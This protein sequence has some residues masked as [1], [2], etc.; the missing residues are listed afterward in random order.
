[1]KK[2][3]LKTTKQKGKH[4]KGVCVIPS[5]DIKKNIKNK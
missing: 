5:N 2:I 4:Q 1:M 3:K